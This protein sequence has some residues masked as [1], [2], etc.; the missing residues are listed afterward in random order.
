MINQNGD[1]PVSHIQFPEISEVAECAGEYYRRD[2]EGFVKAAGYIVENLEAQIATPMTGGFRWRNNTQASPPSDHLMRF[3]AMRDEGYNVTYGIHNTMRLPT[4][5]GVFVHPLDAKA[6]GNFMYGSVNSESQSYQHLLYAAT[7]GEIGHCHFIP[8]HY[9]HDELRRQIN[10]LPKEEVE[11]LPM[12]AFLTSQLYRRNTIFDR[13]DRSDLQED[14]GLYEQFRE[15]GV[16]PLGIEGLYGMASKIVHLE[17]ETNSGI[18]P[19]AARQLG[20]LEEY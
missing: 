3:E 1:K 17:I 20:N 6:V 4:D 5:I 14:L 10:A 2:L 7:H 9:A 16:T 11:L 12:R 19:P 13:I 8:G 18:R 15:E